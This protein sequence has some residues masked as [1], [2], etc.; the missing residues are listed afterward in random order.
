V[1]YG[2]EDVE[3]KRSLNHAV[4]VIHITVILGFTVTSIFFYNMPGFS[5][6]EATRAMTAWTFAAGASD[7]FLTCMMWFIL[8]EKSKSDIFRHGSRSYAVLDVVSSRASVNPSDSE[9]TEDIHVDTS[10]VSRN[11]LLS[12]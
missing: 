4:T 1:K 6:V 2:G 7:I 10:F 11:S 5:A 9:G 8:D 3:Q 12:D